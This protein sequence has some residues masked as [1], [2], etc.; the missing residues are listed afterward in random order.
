MRG[1]FN[2]RELKMKIKMLPARLKKP[3]QRH[4]VGGLKKDIKNT[5][6][7]AKDVLD[8]V[9]KAAGVLLVLPAIVVF[10]YLR[11]ISRPDLFVSSIFSPAGLAALLVATLILCGV[12]LL[13]FGAPSLLAGWVTHSSTNEK[14]TSGTA[15]LIAASG[16][17]SA[18]FYLSIFYIYD[19][20]FSTAVKLFSGITLGV[21]LMA[22]L[23]ALTYISPRYFEVL[24]EDERGKYRRRIWTALCRTALF[25]SVGIYS[26]VAVFFIYLFSNSSN[27]HRSGWW[28]DA[29]IGGIIIVSVWPGAV[30]VYRR[31]L[32]DSAHQAFLK[33]VFIFL[34]TLML[35][36]VA[37]IPIKPITLAA[38]R[39]MGVFET[40]PRTFEIINKS[41]SPVYSAMDF[42]P[43]FGQRIIEATIRFQFGDVRLLCADVYD[44]LSASPTIPES[45]CVTPLKDEIRVLD[46]PKHFKKP[47]DTLALTAF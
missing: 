23:F 41:E 25:S 12:V 26:I 6:S 24:T 16:L 7:L 30:Y 21:F 47:S 9:L 33:A 44:P 39:T 31:S 11:E 5:I 28:Q 17:A 45:G 34:N 3:S 1:S 13:A 18:C 29:F 4:D 37:G 19:A 20:P 2:G 38:M 27:F 42:R 32:G 40:N 10:N 22:I 14:P 36:G 35:L 8:V 46:L 43:V 15:S